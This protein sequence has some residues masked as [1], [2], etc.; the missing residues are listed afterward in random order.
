[1]SDDDAMLIGSV[2]AE[3]EAEC[4]RCGELYAGTAE[5]VLEHH[6]VCTGET[7]ENPMGDPLVEPDVNEVLALAAKASKR[8]ARVLELL[9]QA[10]AEEREEA[11]IVADGGST[12]LPL[13]KSG[14]VR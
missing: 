14:T 4:S 10:E 9:K 3:F 6:R 5:A 13:P 1:M 12:W 2:S 7:P 11:E 8:W